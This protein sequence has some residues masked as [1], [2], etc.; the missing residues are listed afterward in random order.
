MS[1]HRSVVGAAVTTLVLLAMSTAAGPAWA[2]PTTEAAAT[3]TS[4]FA[5]APPRGMEF[6]AAPG[7]GRE[8]AAPANC[9][10]GRS[11][12]RGGHGTGAR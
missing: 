7:S 9:G 1:I 2:S 10:N 5:H 11:C 3:A 12:G 4:A 8:L 6:M